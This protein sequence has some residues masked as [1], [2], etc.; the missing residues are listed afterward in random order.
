M[1]FTFREITK[2]P[3]LAWCAR[4]NVNNNIVTILHGPGV[5]IHDSW[6]YEGAWDGPADSP[7]FVTSSYFS[8]TGACLI[9]GGV[10][11]VSPSHPFRGLVISKFD[12]GYIVSNSLIFVM[13]QIDDEPDINDMEYYQH[14]FNYSQ[15]GFVEKISPI[16]LAKG[17]KIGL[18]YYCNLQIVNGSLNKTKKINPEPPKNFDDYQTRI[19]DKLTRIRENANDPSRVKIKYN[20]IVPLSRGYDSV[21]CA[22][23]AAQAGWKKSFTIVRLNPDEGDAFN[24]DDGT[25]IAEC[26]GLSIDKLSVNAWKELENCPEAEFTATAWSGV[27]V[28]F[29]AIEKDLCNSL[30]VLGIPGGLIWNPKNEKVTDTWKRP[31][32]IQMGAES[33]WEFSLRVGVITIYPVTFMAVHSKNF[34]DIMSPDEM[35]P[36]TLGGE[37]DKPIARRIAE[38]AGVPRELFGQKKM[39][40]AHIYPKETAS[41]NGYRN[42]IQYLHKIGKFEQ[43]ITKTAD[44]EKDKN[45]VYV[46]VNFDKSEEDSVTLDLQDVRRYF[47]HWGVKKLLPRYRITRK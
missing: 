21:A 13:A 1:K 44:V 4:V 16:I 45:H 19:I 46:T 29:S 22:A 39:A 9:D 28:R 30:L 10:E 31:K 2:L 12:H 5:E 37:Y 3:S 11:F 20:P 35:L 7:G 15:A 24:D 38:S 18:H 36:W 47:F 34:H 42:F 17:G 40:S 23:L 43:F 33:L 41:I 27:L 26:L 8:G 6:F 32:K 14:L 25:P